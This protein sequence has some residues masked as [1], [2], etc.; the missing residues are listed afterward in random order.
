MINKMCGHDQI[1]LYSSTGLLPP[2]HQNLTH[3]YTS[4]HGLPTRIHTDQCVQ[5]SGTLREVTS[6]TNAISS[7][8]SFFWWY[9]RS[10]RLCFQK[11][12]ECDH[13]EKY[14]LSSGA[15]SGV[16]CAAFEDELVV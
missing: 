8:I 2:R 10:A 3:E 5:F 14:V 15:V 12:L 1:L 16:K 11:V 6:T 13:K 9:L 7:L 4:R